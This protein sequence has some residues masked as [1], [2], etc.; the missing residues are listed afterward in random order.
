MD[1]K[2]GDIVARKS[3]GSDILFKVADIKNEGGKR[4]AIL[5]G[6]CYRLEADAPESD[7][8]IQPE[9]YVREYNAR[10]N[11][12]VDEKVRNITAFTFKKQK[13]NSFAQLLK[14]EIRTFQGLV[15]C[16]ILMGIMII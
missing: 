1:F 15:G 8:M 3:Y 6:I 11:M 5:K 10:V 16:F 4:V 13:K 7:L 12:S 2:I 9:S 14:K